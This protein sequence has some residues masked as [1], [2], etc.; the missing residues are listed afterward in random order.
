MRSSASALFVAPQSFK[1]IDG[2]RLELLGFYR[3]RAF[4]A[5][6][7]FTGENES[8]LDGDADCTVRRDRLIRMAIKRMGDWRAFYLERQH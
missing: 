2:L 7:F 8:G 6:K 1:R 5:I 4:L 3:G